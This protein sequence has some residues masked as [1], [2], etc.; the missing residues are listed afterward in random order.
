M[1]TL[2]AGSR[3]FENKVRCA[4]LGRSRPE[5]SWGQRVRLGAVLLWA[6][7]ACGGPLDEWTVRQ[8]VVPHDFG[9]LQIGIAG[10]AYGNG[11]FLA[12]GPHG[13]VLASSDGT[14]WETV[15]SDYTNSFLALLYGNGA[16]LGTGDNWEL[17]HS[18]DGQAWT[19]T[20]TIRL[21]T[22]HRP[23][24]RYSF[25]QRQYLFTFTGGQF[26]SIVRTW[27][28]GYGWVWG[29]AAPS[30]GLEW[31]RNVTVPLDEVFDMAVGDGWAVALG[32]RYEG[33]ADTYLAASAIPTRKWERI[34]VGGMG[35]DDLSYPPRARLR[36]AFG[37]GV[38]VGT[39][40]SALGLWVLRPG[41]PIGGSQPLCEPFWQC[42]P[43]ELG[44]A[45]GRFIGVG[46]GIITST[47]GV[48]WTVRHTLPEGA[49]PLWHVAYGNGRFVAASDDTILQSGPIVWLQGRWREGMEIELTGTKGATY[50][51]EFKE[52]GEAADWQGLETLTLTNETQ[53]IRDP[54][55]LAAPGRI[56]RAEYLSG[57]TLG[58]ATLNIP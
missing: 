31:K 54:G 3:G 21:Y 14:S 53:V 36:C 27:A 40:P 49:R 12:V 41:Q 8:K 32:R 19:P 46:R 34:R 37:N 25:L 7:T 51:I 42:Y 35:E 23:S 39:M 30:D 11:Q 22:S 48:H 6:V 38:F 56:Y 55:S 2:V 9:G 45:A 28:P 57:P 43:E 17:V 47:D 20:S 50:R 4:A 44:F 29:L 15:R 18:T 24:P 58:P 1:R 10:L 26:A 52:P 5:L 13:L 16:W 33:L